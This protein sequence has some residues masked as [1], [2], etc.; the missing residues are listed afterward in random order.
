MNFLEDN[1][2]SV[3]LKLFKPFWAQL[4]ENIGYSR[5]YKRYV[6]VEPICY[7]AEYNGSINRC[8]SVDSIV[9]DLDLG[10][11]VAS[12]IDAERSDYVEQALV[13][14]IQN[15][16]YTYILITDNPVTFSKDRLPEF[17]NFL[18]RE[19]QV[20]RVVRG[21][22][23]YH[24]DEPRLSGGDINAMIRF[25]KEIKSLGGTNQIGMLLSEKDPMDTLEI[26][27]SGKKKFIEHLSA[28]LVD[29]RIDVVGELFTGEAGV[30]FPLDIRTDLLSEV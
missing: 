24:V 12:F 28:K 15:K 20:L 27:K 1:K 29:G 19:T 5:E 9:Y 25:T 3:D 4:F 7:L 18:K 16:K 23:H 2:V 17:L 14:Y 10:P 11:T 8:A 30:H 21:L 6:I 22:V 26:K 13:P